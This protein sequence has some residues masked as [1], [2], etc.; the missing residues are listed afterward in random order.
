MALLK[1][2]LNDAISNYFVEKY[3]AKNVT[4]RVKNDKVCSIALLSARCQVH[5]SEAKDDKGNIVKTVTFSNAHHK[6]LVIF[7]GTETATG[8][9]SVN[10]EAEELEERFNVAT[11]VTTS[12]WMTAAVFIKWI[13]KFVPQLISSKR[14]CAR[15]CSQKLSSM[16]PPPSIHHFFLARLEPLC[17]KEVW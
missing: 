1:H 15:L 5:I 9:N 12:G 11:A 14:D 7:S 6:P 4:V 8:K 2:P 13:G 10:R 3:G 16:V 17:A